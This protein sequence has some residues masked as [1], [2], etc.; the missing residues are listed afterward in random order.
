MTSFMAQFFRQQLR[1]GVREIHRRRD[2]AA[3]VDTQARFQDGRAGVLFSSDVSAR[4]M[5]YPNVTLVVQFGAPPSREHYIHRVGRTARAGKLGRA[6]LLLG[7]LEQGFL[8]T[9]EDL[10]LTP[11]QDEDSLRRTSELLVRGMTSWVSSA[12]MRAA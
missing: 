8:R 12:S 11:L 2:A 3:R 9:V 6:V 10:P 7:E 4:G 5:D 1:I